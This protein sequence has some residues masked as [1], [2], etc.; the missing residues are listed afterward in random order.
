MAA[1]SSSRGYVGKLGG[2]VPSEFDRVCL[3]LDRALISR[4]DRLSRFIGA[5]GL[6]DL[7]REELIV[8]AIERYLGAAEMAAPGI[9]G[10][11]LDTQPPSC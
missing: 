5:S 2:V 3:D 11:P 9:A 10:L 1:G 6:A 7:S 4:L 8:D